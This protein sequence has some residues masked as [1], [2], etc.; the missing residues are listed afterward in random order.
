VGLFVPVSLLNELRRKLV[1]IID[2]NDNEFVLPEVVGGTKEIDIF[3]K[4]KFYLNSFGERVD[5]KGKD[6]SSCWVVLP[7]ICRN[8]EALKKLVAECYDNGARKFMVENYYGFEV[9]RKYND[10]EIGVGSFIYVMNEYATLE[11]KNMGAKWCV[12]ALES[13]LDNKEKVIEKS[14]IEVKKQVDYRVP[15]FTSAV[16]IR[17]NDCKNCKGGIKRYELKK[18]GRKY[19]AISK[20]CMVSVFRI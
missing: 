3:E 17:G 7:Q 20:D 6:I 1:D 15:L 4:D 16:C 10:I 12:V 9:L 19:E 18:D 5:F 14:V 8:V 13:S 2:I 11:L